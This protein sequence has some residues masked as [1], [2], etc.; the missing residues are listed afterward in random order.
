MLPGKFLF[1]ISTAFIPFPLAQEKNEK[2]YYTN[3]KGKGLGRFSKIKS[4][5]VNS[6]LFPDVSEQNPFMVIKADPFNIT[7]PKAVV[8]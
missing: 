6:E 1:P 4:I 2:T 7:F 8:K 3:F 5:S